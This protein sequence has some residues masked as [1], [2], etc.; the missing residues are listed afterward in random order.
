MNSS[1]LGSVRQEGV[2]LVHKSMAFQPARAHQKALFDAGIPAFV[3]ITKD[4]HVEY[5]HRLKKQSVISRGVPKN[6]G[7]ITVVLFED[8][9][10]NLINLVQPAAYPFAQIDVGSKGAKIHPGCGW[11]AFG[12]DS[13]FDSRVF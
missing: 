1:A 6:M 11:F 3:L 7:L 12:D 5:D 2:D 13:L 10:G 4:I 8:S 9:C